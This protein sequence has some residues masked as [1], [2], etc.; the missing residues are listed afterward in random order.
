MKKDKFG[1]SIGIVSMI[2]VFAV[3]CLVVFSSL[4]LVTANREWKLAKEYAQSV[5]DYYAADTKATHFYEKVIT[6]NSLRE[7]KT[8]NFNIQVDDKQELDVA[9]T[10]TAKGFRITS[11]KLVPTQTWTTDDSM[12]VWSGDDE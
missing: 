1:I 4:T 11:W 7:G 9:F 5:T 10:R 2:M 12:N 3:L 6:E 8:M